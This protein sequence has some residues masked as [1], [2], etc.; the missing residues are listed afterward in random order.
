MAGKC[1][2]F[3]V[4]EAFW[5]PGAVPRRPCGLPQRSCGTVV[6]LKEAPGTEA[7]SEARMLSR[8]G[9]LA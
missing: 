1:K 6:L 7:C 3:S 5:R 9:I 8:G 2:G 4:R